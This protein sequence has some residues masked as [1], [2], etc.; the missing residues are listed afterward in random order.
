V[1]NTRKLWSAHLHSLAGP[2]LRSLIG[3]LAAHHGLPG[4][5]RLLRRVCAQL[6][7]LSPPTAGLVAAAV[8]ASCHACL[9]AR[10][11]TAAV[12]GRLM[13]FLAWLVSQPAVKSVVNAQ[14]FLEETARNV[15]N[16][17]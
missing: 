3:L 8:L 5:G 12:A 10:A 16:A 11:G 2:E 4:L 17:P 9:Q 7:G 14:L 1:L 6:I 13:A 15:G